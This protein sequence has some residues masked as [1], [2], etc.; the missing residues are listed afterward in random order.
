MAE[1]VPFVAAQQPWERV[2]VVICGTP[3]IPLDPGTE[4]V[5]A[6]SRTCR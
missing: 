6:S 4:V 2:D 1:E 5:V 3:E